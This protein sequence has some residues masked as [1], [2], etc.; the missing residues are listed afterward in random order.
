SRRRQ[1]R[2]S[3]GVP[4]RRAHRPR[5]ELTRSRH[6][7]RPDE[8]PGGGSLVLRTTLRSLWQ[9]KRRL[10]STT[11]AVLLGVAFMAG[12]FVL[13]DTLDNSIDEL[14]GEVTVGIDAEVRGP[15]L[16]DSGFGALRG[17]LDAA[18]V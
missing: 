2:R 5:P 4:R 8:A 7:H 9:H 17:P 18:L 11:V 3:G 14:V 16:F 6:D 10:I 12:T 13:G 15:E 1:L